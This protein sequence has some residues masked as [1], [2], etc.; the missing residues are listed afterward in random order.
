MDIA[1]YKAFLISAETGSFSKAAEILCYTPSG[2]SQLVKALEK[3][4]GFALFQRN[5]KGV[6]LTS[7]GQKLLPEI[8]TLVKQEQ[9]INQIVSELN[10]LQ[11]GTVTIAS[12]V[13]IATYWLPYVIKVFQQKYT[14][15]QLKIMEGTRNEIDN[16]FEQGIVDI[17]F[18]SY[19]EPM[20]YDWI[21]LAEIP[22]IA[23]LPKDHAF[24]HSKSYPLK[25][26]CNEK[27]IMPDLGREDDIIAMFN[28]NGITPN[29]CFSTVEA[30]STIPMIEQGLGISIM[31]ELLT[32]RGGYDIVKL[33][34]EPPQYIT[35]GIIAK[36]FKK[37]APAPQRFLKYAVN[38]LTQV[39]MS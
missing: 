4:F 11:T 6:I 29:I 7:Y 14:Q 2:V 5:K 3:E 16:W 28:R 20:H 13:S 30:F 12:Y 18:T 37:L 21:P 34:L 39:E 27:F 22:M 25:N 19:I 36:D 31:N 8:R 15:I 10:G 33:P 17:G 9:H 23:V 32:K 24:A 38:L 35:L 26:C 1:R